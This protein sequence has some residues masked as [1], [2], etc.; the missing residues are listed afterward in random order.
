MG[1]ATQ[2]IQQWKEN[3]RYKGEAENKRWIKNGA[4]W[5]KPSKGICS[6]CNFDAAINEEKNEVMLG[7]LIRDDKGRCVEVKNEVVRTGADA[8]TWEALSGR[9]IS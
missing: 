6:K 2:L 4:T 1:K 5:T 3:Q 8:F 7:F 9:Q